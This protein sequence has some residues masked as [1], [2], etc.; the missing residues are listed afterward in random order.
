MLNMLR[1]RPR[2]WLLDWS[3][4]A[5]TTRVIKY[6]ETLTRSKRRVSCVQSLWLLDMY[7]KRT[8]VVGKLTY[9]VDAV[10][11]DVHQ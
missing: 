7:N 3:P 6:K 4:Y 1:R 9:I 10:D 8:A 11:T 5:K 2:L